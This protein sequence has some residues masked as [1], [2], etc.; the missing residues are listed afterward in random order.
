MPDPEAGSEW[1][2]GTALLRYE[3]RGY[4]YNEAIKRHELA[5]TLVMVTN[6]GQEV[7]RPSMLTMKKQNGKWKGWP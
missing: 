7:K 1:C 6:G 2:K 5:V 4:R 3:I